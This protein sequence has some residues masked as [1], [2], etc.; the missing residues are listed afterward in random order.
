MMSEEMEGRSRCWRAWLF[1]LGPLVVTVQA[2]SVGKQW[3]YQTGGYV[4]WSSPALSPDQTSSAITDN[5]G[6]LKHWVKV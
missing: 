5:Y 2:G 4:G 1:V 3:S 6:K